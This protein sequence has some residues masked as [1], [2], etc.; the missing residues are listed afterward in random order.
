MDAETCKRELVIQIPFDVVQ[1]ESESIAGEYARKARVPGFRPGRAPRDL[2]LQRYREEIREEVVQ[3]LLPRFF[4]D[5]IKEQELVLAGKP[6]FEDVKFEDREPLTSKAVF[7]VYPKFEPVEYKG[8]DVDEAPVVVTGEDVDRLL[9]QAQ[10]AAATFEVVDRPGED[11]DVLSV[12]Y[13]AWDVRSPKIRLVDVEQGAVRLGE[14]TTLPEFNENLRGVRPGEAREFDVKYPEDFP[15][16]RLAGKAARFRVEVL[17][18]KRK[19][20]PPLDDELA[21]TVGSYSNLEELRQSLRQQL[22]ERRRKEAEAQTKRKLLDKLLERTSFPV[23]ATLVEERIDRR[24]VAFATQLAEEGIDVNDESINWAQMRAEIRPQAEDD[25][26]RSM[27]LEKV[28]DAESIE[29]SE[30]EVDEAIRDMTP[31]RS[32]ESPAALKTRLTRNGGLARLQSSLRNQKALDLIYRDAHVIP[33]TA[34]SSAPSEPQ[35]AHEPQGE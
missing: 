30:A 34:A 35:Q 7:E 2:I 32:G 23:P 12:S 19:V 8:L 15:Q 29:V 10:Q 31:Q 27:L 1:K 18:V 16:K 3:T 33:A 28:A 6:H 11:G 17:G 9:E 14:K 22:T 4:T 25:I 26:R 24:L 13:R 21:K 5:A 20:V